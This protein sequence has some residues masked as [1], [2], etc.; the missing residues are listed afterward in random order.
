MPLRG[1]RGIAKDLSFARLII[2]HW[3]KWGIS[4]GV[5]GVESRAGNLKFFPKKN[6][7]SLPNN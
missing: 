2:W 7:I 4:G 5:G 1:E 6:L 3:Q